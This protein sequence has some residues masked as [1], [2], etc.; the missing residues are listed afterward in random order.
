M[1]RRKTER[2]DQELTASIMEYFATVPDPRVERS[3][4]HPLESILAL[5]VC[6]VICGADTFVAI[7]EY[8]LAKEAWLKSFI[9][10]PNGIPSHDTLGRVF[11]A[12]NPTALGDAFREWVA[13]LSRLTK[14]QVIAID[15]KTL[16]R[17]FRKAG[18]SSFVHM[19]SAWAT[20]NRLVLGQVKTEEKSNEITAIPRLLELLVIKGCLVTIDAMGCQKEIAKA[21]VERDADWLLAVKENQPTLRQDLIEVF[22]EARRKP[23]VLATMDC[24]VTEEVGHGRTEVRRCWTTHMLSQVQ[25]RAEWPKLKSLVLVEAE[26]TVNGKTSTE[27]RYYI[28][29]RPLFS[30]AAALEAVRAHWGIENQLHWVLDVAFREDDCRVRVGNAAENLTVMRHI[31]LNLLKSVPGTK[32]GIKTRRHRAG[33][34]DAFLLRVLA[35]KS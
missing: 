28:S 2:E 25:Q 5:S 16:R 1:A 27:Q 6:A 21:I 3:R 12:L 32:V 18:S 31:A 17:S 30:A 34:D 8:G 13:S 19:V 15:G 23:E 20:T 4:L 35:G 22:D 9:D 11:A 7:E 26:R 10:L 14:G 24:A 33:W 29:S